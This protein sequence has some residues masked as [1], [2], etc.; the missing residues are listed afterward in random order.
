M[1]FVLEFPD[2]KT[3]N[4]LIY[5]MGNL[6]STMKDRYGHAGL[7]MLPEHTDVMSPLHPEPVGYFEVSDEAA[8][9]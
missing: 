3:W 8:E 5:R 9:A 4:Q 2:V 1:K 6:T 7:V